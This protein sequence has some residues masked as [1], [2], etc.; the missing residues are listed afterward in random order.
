MSEAKR[1][2]DEQGRRLAELRP[3]I[4]RFLGRRLR[5]QAEAEDLT[6]ET[7]ARLLRRS[8][9]DQVQ[10]LEGYLFQIASN[11]LR[12]RAR[13]LGVRAAPNAIEL[14]RSFLGDEEV[15]SPERIYLG[16]ESY[17]RLIEAMQELPERTR[18][19]FILSRFED[20]TGN[21]ISRRLGV[22]ISTVEKTLMRA[23]KHL[24]DRVR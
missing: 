9:D 16:R 10:N 3:A 24:R 4:L 23:L 1:R 17:Q 18:T 5:S 2:D 21:Q 12:E 20:M 15:P 7:F 8:S 14:E 6:Q 13:A 19:V 22:S 11:L